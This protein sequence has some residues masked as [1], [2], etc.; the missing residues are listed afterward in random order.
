M[1][2]NVDDSQATEAKSRQTA[3]DTVRCR[4]RGEGPDMSD[5]TPRCRECGEEIPA[6]RL[7]RVPDAERCRDCQEEAEREERL[8]KTPE[9][10]E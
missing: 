4:P 3:I 9:E 5:G 1:V 7:V 2:D 10:T 8:I 6:A